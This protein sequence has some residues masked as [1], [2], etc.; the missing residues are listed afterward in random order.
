METQCLVKHPTII[1]SFTVVTILMELII[2]V[3]T[4]DTGAVMEIAMAGMVN[5]GVVTDTVT[6]MADTTGVDMEEDIVEIKLAINIRRLQCG[7]HYRH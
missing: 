3:E 7:S 6:V 1:L 5:T 2:M 4:A